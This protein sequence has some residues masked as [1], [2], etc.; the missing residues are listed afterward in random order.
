[1]AAEDHIDLDNMDPY[2]WETLGPF[3]STG[4]TPA[5][6]RICN[7]WGPWWKGPWGWEID[8]KCTP[9]TIDDFKDLTAP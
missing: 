4:P 1:M 7:K 5:R 8:H 6:C 9:V 2:E 3:P